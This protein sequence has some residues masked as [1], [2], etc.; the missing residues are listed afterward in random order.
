MKLTKQKNS[1]YTKEIQD[2]IYNTASKYLKTLGWNLNDIA[3]YFI[4]DVEQTEDNRIHVEIRAELEYED[5]DKLMEVL[6]RV[7]NVKFDK[8]AYFDMVQ[9][10]IAEAY[11][12]IPDV[13]AST[14]D[15]NST[16]LYWYF[17]THGVQPGSIPKYA[18]VEDIKDTPNG[19]YFSTYAL[20]STEDLDKYDIV[21]RSPYDDVEM[22]TDIKAYQFEETED[23]WGEDVERVLAAVFERTEDLMY[24]VRNT[25]RGARTNCET[26]EDLAEFIRDLS[27]EFE[28]TASEIEDL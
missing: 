21:E 18:A 22:S 10:G 13:Q 28:E 8:D 25:V 26:T 14:S 7:I 19:S 12:R 6:D 27:N 23:G 4:C 16:D 9:P 3:D 11:I 15:T 2:S 24:E 17:T 5:M 1:S 20:I